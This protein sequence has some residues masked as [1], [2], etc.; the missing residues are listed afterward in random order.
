M[1]A[2]PDNLI[3]KLLQELRGDMKLLREEVAE[4]KAEMRAGMTAF[5]R[6]MRAEMADF[7][8]EVRADLKALDTRL[9][10][11]IVDLRGTVVLY[12]S[13]VV[14]H[15]ILIGDLEARVARVERHLE[16]PAIDQH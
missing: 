15:G 9:S 2:E 8:Q 13:S 3:I 7:R 6:E 12:H 11:Q 14:G 1:P 10:Y 5:T 4:F 16:L